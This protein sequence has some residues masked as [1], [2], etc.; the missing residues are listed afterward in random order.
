MSAARPIAAGASS[1]SLARRLRLGA[2]GGAATPRFGGVTGQRVPR[3]TGHPFW[4]GCLEPEPRGSGWWTAD[5]E[6][7]C[8][9]ARTGVDGARRRPIATSLASPVGPPSCLSRGLPG[10]GDA[11]GEVAIPAIPAPQPNFK[12]AE[13]AVRK[14]VDWE[15]TVTKQINE[16]MDLAIKDNDHITRNFLNWFME[17]QLEEVSS[18]ETLLS[19]V[20]RAGES[21]LLFVENY[22]AQG[23]K[24]AGTE[25]GGNS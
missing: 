9:I 25:A 15:V 12:S 17:E 14:S 19:M 6:L 18:M 16:L 22:L 20:R 4:R 8:I 10:M 7:G 11:S 24:A 1:V 23:Q 2:Q 13:E 21:G 5:R 3:G